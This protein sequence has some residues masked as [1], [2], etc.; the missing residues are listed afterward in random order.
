MFCQAFRAVED[1]IYDNF[2]G[3][4]DVGLFSASVQQTVYDTQV[5]ILKAIPQIEEIYMA[6]PNKHYFSVDLSKFPKSVG[7]ADRN[8]EVFLPVDKPSG[9]IT[10]TMGRKDLRAKL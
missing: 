4:N 5:Q 6:F 3:P 8:D 9:Y 2:A 7:G 10:S 1:A